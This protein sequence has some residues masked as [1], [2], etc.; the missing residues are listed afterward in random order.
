VHADVGIVDVN[1]VRAT[2]ER[3]IQPGELGVGIGE[4]RDGNHSGGSKAR[5]DITAGHTILH[6]HARG[7][8]RERNRF[9]GATQ[10]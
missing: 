2:K 1:L 3:D 8:F 4:G 5:E 6:L 7:L 10:T 9:R